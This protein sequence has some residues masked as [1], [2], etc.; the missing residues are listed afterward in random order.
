MMAS[1]NIGSWIGACTRRLAAQTGGAMLTACAPMRPPLYLWDSFP[2]Q[3]YDALL[4][5]GASPSEQIRVLQAQA[6]KARGQGA[7]L[8]PGFRA[9]LGMLH[10]NVGDVDRAREM[11]LAEKVAFPESAGYMDQLLK[12]LDAPAGNTKKS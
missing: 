12:R 1:L 8:P 4:R 7:A 5:E 10:L 9:H 6:E 3:Q 2:R 11:W